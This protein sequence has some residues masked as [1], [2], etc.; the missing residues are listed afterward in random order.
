MA[1]QHAA[2][3]LPYLRRLRQRDPQAV[4]RWFLDHVDP[5][6]TF[7]FYRVNRDPALAEDVVQETFLTAL[8]K[9]GSF[10]PERGAMHPWLTY[11]A[12]NCI[13]AALRRRGLLETVG[14][15][16]DRIDERLAAAF[17]QLGDASLPDALVERRET[18][19]LVQ[20]ALANIPEK[21]RRALHSHYCRERSLEEIAASL[22]TSASAVKSLLHRARLAF[23][24]A[25]QTIADAWEPRPPKR[26]ILP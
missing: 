12:R 23:K 26:R 20:M 3:D 25:F 22:E 21:Y 19:E 5:L 11:T 16:W 24:A 9:I 2:A 18:V 7:V 1:S 14:E 13:R 8:G 17:R 4:E 10:D 6:Y 15:T